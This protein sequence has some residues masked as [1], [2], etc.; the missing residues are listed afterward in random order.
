MWRVHRDER[1]PPG[2][3]PP[4]THVVDGVAFV[5]LVQALRLLGV[6]STGSTPTMVR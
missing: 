5:P 6:L 4:T 3:G 2:G 1:T